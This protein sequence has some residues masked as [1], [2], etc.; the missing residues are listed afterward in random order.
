M[1]ALFIHQNFPGQFTHL[2]PALARRGD[3]V[4][5][6]G[7]TPKPAD[8]VRV[9]T[10]RPDRGNTRGI[11]PYAQEFETKMLRADACAQAMTRLRSEGFAPDVVIT[12]PGWG[13][14]IFAKDVWP[15]ARLLNY[16]EFFYRAEG[17]D[18]GFDP[19]FADEP[20]SVRF[21]T[22]AKNACNLIALDQMDLGLSPTR[23][24]AST[25]PPLYRDRIRVIFDGID[26]QRVRPDA[27]VSLVLAQGTPRQRT[28]RPGDEVI[29][30]V[31]RNLEP[32]RGYHRFMR[33]LPGILARRP[34]AVAIIVGGAD[35]S[36][37]RPPPEGTTWQQHF[38]DEVKDALD[39]ARVFFVGK[40]PYASYLRLLQLS[41]CHVYLTYPFVLSWSCIEALSAGCVVV[42]S[43]TAPVREVIDPGRN[44][45]L[46]GFHDTAALVD[47][48]VDVLSDPGAYAA[49]RAR[50]RAGAVE[51]YDLSSRC[52]PA[53]LRLI[54]ELAAG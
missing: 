12:N 19:E 46:V 42:G 6:L 43:D 16:L 35:V 40:V 3:E 49:M 38:L 18:V 36:Y 20:T 30:F 2:A 41:A 27:G 44:G 13:E 4:R 54:D 53:Q 33:A 25:M 50:A 32:Y 11:H 22:R 1:R 23:W 39:L 52:L 5:A 28:V 45:I 14:A 37:G 10:Y 24:Q 21:R 34:N 7:I 51:Q 9:E 31:N 29:T 47:R 8:G 48:V 26:T 15:S 17:A